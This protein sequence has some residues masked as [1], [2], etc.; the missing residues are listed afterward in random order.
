MGTVL[1]LEEVPTG[2]R[3]EILEINASKTSIYF[4]DNVVSR[5]GYFSDKTIRSKMINSSI[6]SRLHGLVRNNETV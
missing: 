4:V 5:R 3:E 2:R 1:L 6:A